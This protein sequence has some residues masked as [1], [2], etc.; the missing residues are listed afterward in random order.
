MGISTYLFGIPL[1]LVFLSSGVLINAVQLVICLLLWPVNRNWYRRLNAWVIN[2]H[3][4]QL[5]WLVDRWA[6][7]RVRFHG[8]P[9]MM[10]QLSDGRRLDQALVVCNHRSGIDWLLGWVFSTRFKRLG[11][12]KAMVKK[13]LKYV[14]VLGWGWYFCEYVFL[15][16][17]WAKDAKTLSRTYEVA[18]LVSFCFSALSS[19]LSFTS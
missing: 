1:L 19:L 6:G 2:L 14:P 13:S 10:A 12:T 17:D 15:S 11:H 5:V 8:D 18:S 16:R 7:V 4:A 3:W 9:A